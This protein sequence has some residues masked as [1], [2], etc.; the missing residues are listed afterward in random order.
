VVIEGLRFG[1]PCRTAGQRRFG[2]VKADGL[3]CPGGHFEGQDRLGLLP[4]AAPRGH[5]AV[6]DLICDGPGYASYFRVLSVDPQHAVVYRSI[7]H[8]RRGSPIDIT[9][10]A[11]PQRAEQQLREAGTYFDF[12]WPWY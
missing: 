11:F 1:P 12:T 2:A 3:G 6:G 10:P 9:D 7:R 4:G 5:V 8:P